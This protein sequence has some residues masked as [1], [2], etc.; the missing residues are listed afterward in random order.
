MWRMPL[1]R[2]IR[3]WLPAAVVAAGLVIAPAAEA[4]LSEKHV[5]AIRRCRTLAASAQIR[6]FTATARQERTSPS[7]ITFAE[8]LPTGRLEY[9]S[10]SEIL[11]R[12]VSHF[13]LAGRFLAFAFDTIDEVEEYG[14]SETT[15]LLNVETGRERQMPGTFFKEPSRGTAQVV[16]TPAGSVAWMIEGLFNQTAT[17]YLF[18]RAI[19]ALRAGARKPVLL[20]SSEETVP[21]SLAA[22]P[23]HIYWLEAGTARTFAAP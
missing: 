10:S 8:W 3:I 15:A 18:G 2:A 9:L 23:G 12:G 21:M 1:R 7:S 20:A 14:L 16:L 6:V 17:G 22:T 19:Y 4:R 13:A 5:C 11:E